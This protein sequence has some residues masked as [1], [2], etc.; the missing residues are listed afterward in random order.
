[1]I[2]DEQATHSLFTILDFLRWGVSQMT[3]HQAYF[4]HGTDNAWDEALFLITSALHLPYPFRQEYLSARL[5]EKEKEKIIDLFKRRIKEKIPAPYLVR[6]AWF[7][8]LT[9]YV[10]ERVLIPR[11]P[12][13]ELIHRHFS[14]WIQYDADVQ[15]ILDLCTGSACIA[16]ACA[17]AFPEALVDAVDIDK[18]AL[19]VAA[20][21]IRRHNV[22]DQVTLWESDLFT[23]LPQKKY[24]I[25]ISNPPYI[26][27]DEFAGL[28]EEYR[29][30]PSIALL[31]QT[32]SPDGLEIAERILF[33]AKNY[34]KPEGILII[35]VGNAEAALSEKYPDIPFLWLGFDNGGSGVFLLTA[36]QL[37]AV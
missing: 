12:I 8:G 36:E 26:S 15:N 19:Q 10:D 6:E 16:I 5:T 14:P 7:A 28:P 24:D 29:Q 23:A 2:N 13:A 21:N 35:E 32:G 34:L 9:F 17:Y 4:G 11:S 27:A 31:S 25:I 30:E 37:K 33:N 20:E 1:M 22:E 18:P 3:A